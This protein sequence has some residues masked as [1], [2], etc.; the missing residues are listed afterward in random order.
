VAAASD[1]EAVADQ[2]DQFPEQAVRHAV[3]ELRSAILPRLRRDTGGDQRLSGMRSGARLDVTVETT[4]TGGQVAAGPRRMR[5]PW[6]WLNDG[7]RPRA[8]GRGRHPGTPAKGTWDRPVAKALPDVEREVA[9]L[10]DRTV[11]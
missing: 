3:T 11:G 7:T 10:F 5:G 1:L 2:L 4:G 9:T 6:R 8:Q